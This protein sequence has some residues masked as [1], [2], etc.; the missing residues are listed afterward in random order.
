LAIPVASLLPAYLFPDTGRLGE[1]P[2]V[3]KLVHA[4]FYGGLTIL[5]LWCA[6]RPPTVR[7]YALTAAGATAYGL[8]ME[9]LQHFTPSRSMDLRDALA[10]ALGACLVAGVA[11]GIRTRKKAAT[12]EG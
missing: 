6:R 2:G 4:L 7:T 9:L 12:A 11:L 10:N 5:L 3:D 8:L 1:L